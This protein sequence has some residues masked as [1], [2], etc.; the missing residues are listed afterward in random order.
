MQ[1][2]TTSFY[3]ILQYANEILGIE[4][5]VTSITIFFCFQRMPGVDRFVRDSLRQ[6]FDDGRRDEENYGARRIRHLH[7]R[8]LALRFEGNVLKVM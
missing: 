8:S 7:G 2:V 5:V 1:R 4:L 6:R 3:H